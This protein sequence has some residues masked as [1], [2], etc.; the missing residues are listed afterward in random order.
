ML[1]KSIVIGL[2]CVA[3]HPN[4]ADFLRFMIDHFNTLIDGIV[5]HAVRRI[6]SDGHLLRESWLPMANQLQIDILAL[7]ALKLL[8]G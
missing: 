8:K 2:S 5:E 3:P 7:F 4:V 1:D 6:P